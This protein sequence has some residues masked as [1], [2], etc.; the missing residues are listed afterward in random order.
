MVGQNRPAVDR[1]AVAVFWEVVAA[2]GAAHQGQ[3]HLSVIVLL[4]Y[5]VVNDG[6]REFLRRH[7]ELTYGL[8]DDFAHNILQ[9]TKLV[10]PLQFHEYFFLLPWPSEPLY[11][12][13]IQHKFSIFAA[14]A[15]HPLYSLLHALEH[16]SVLVDRL[17]FSER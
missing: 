12:I 9:K 11:A 13:E 6:R 2:P 5:R 10:V 1:G 16:L 15:D 7:H 14:K 17:S 3:V 8:F 4:P